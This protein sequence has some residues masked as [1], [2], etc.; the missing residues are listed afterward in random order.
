M[1]LIELLGRP[2]HG[3]GNFDDLPKKA[4]GL[5][6]Y[7][8]MYSGRA[9]PREKLVDLLWTNSAAE[10]GRHSLRQSLAAIR[11]ALGPDARDHIKTTGDDVLF[12]TSDVIEVDAR[13]F[14]VLAQSAVLADL[15]AA[16]ELYRGEFLADFDVESEAFMDWVGLERNRLELM[17][18]G[19][20]YRLATTLSNSCDHDNAII[21]AQ[22]LVGVDA[23]R[24]D[25]H[26]LL[27]Q[28]YANVGRRGEAIR[29]FVSCSDHLRRELGV[30]PDERTVALADAIRA[31]TS[32]LD[33]VQDTSANL[34]PDGGVLTLAAD[35]EPAGPLPSSADGAEC[36]AATGAVINRSREEGQPS[37]Y[38]G[39]R[40]PL[41]IMA[42]ELTWLTAYPDVEDFLPTNEACYRRCA[43]IIER[44]HGYIARCAGDGLIAYFGYPHARE[45]D[46]E[47]SVRAA[48]ALRQLAAQLS[49]E[50]GTAVQLCT[51]IATGI[52]VIGDEQRT[53]EQTVLGDTLILSLSSRL[54]AMAKPGQ[55]II[56]RS[57]QRLLGR[58][59][60]YHEQGG[61]DLKGLPTPVETAQVLGESGI[62]S[63]F[64]AHHPAKLTPVV[65]R[66]EEIGLL[67]RRW[68]RAKNGEGSIVL[69]VGE[70]G[71]GKSRIAQAALDLLSGER[72]ARWRLFCSPH[73]QDSPLFPFTNQL[74]RAS[75]FRR[76]DTNEERLLKL[77]MM[78]GQS[79]T[80]RGNAMAL[81][82][83]LLSIPTG[84]RY[85]LPA[86]TPQQRKEKTLEALAA[87]VEGLAASQP[88]LLVF[89]DVHWAD[90]TSLELLDLI[91]ERTPQRRLLLILTARP[92]FASPWADRI[93]TT[94]VALGR[95]PPRQS[96]AIIAGVVQGKYLPKDISNK[97]LDRADGIPLFIEELTKAVVESDA[98][99]GDGDHGTAKGPRPTPEIPM[100]LH[101]SLLARID[102]TGP[103]RE[104]VQIG[105]AL[106]RRFS[107][108]LISA[109]AAMPQHR[110]EEALAGLVEAEL[111]WRRGN[112]P[113]AEYTFKHALVQE[114]AYG[115]LRRE[116][117]RSLHARIAE[118][119][120]SQF[121]NIADAR[122]ELLAHHYTEAGLLEK[123]AALW[124]KAGQLSLARSALKEASA[125]LTRALDLIEALP[126]TPSLRQ[127]QIKLQIAFANS[128][129]H[130][131]GY[132]A[133]ETKK[134]LAYARLLVERAEVLGEPT[135]DPLLLLSVL[136]GFWVANHVAFNGDAV[137]DLAVEFITLAQ[138]QKTVF[139]LVV[140]HRVMGTS[141]LYLGEI[142]ESLTHLDR[143]L[144]L[145]EP[146]EQRALA[147]RFGQ[148]AGV[149]I[150]SNRP[151]ALWL[152]GYPEAALTDA[153]EAL[154]QARRFGQTATLL[155]AL[156]RIAWFHLVIGNY[157]TAAAQ[158]RELLAV[159]ENMEGSYW[160]AAA[161]MLQGCLFALTGNGA[162]AIDMIT[163][164]I[165]ASRLTG[166]NL[167][168]MPWY[169]SC[170]A[171]AHIALGQFDEAKRYI[172]EALSAMGTTKESWQ[173]SDI[174][175]IAGDLE[176][177][178]IEPNMGNAQTYYEHAVT[179]AREQKAKSWEL[180][181][182]TGL[183][184]LWRQQGRREDALALLAPI[185]GWFT[186]GFYTAD[187]RTARALLDE[188]TMG[189]S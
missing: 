97:I 159:T 13:R 67:L 115:T 142:A 14:E 169:L 156:T 126:G 96:E 120:E 104:I 59:F 170:L 93:Q 58:I 148:D 55:I 172:C 69:L 2:R 79:M 101:A 161:T 63:R 111:I 36:L 100:T 105:A 138:T 171:T 70:P 151:L 86:L 99:A 149:A 117:R 145:Y 71:I 177:M 184:L 65:G 81:F 26:R 76:V 110:L 157:D 77:E 107:H 64:E 139:P 41:T 22:R 60:D 49:T 16:N 72:H 116:P 112:P 188:L 35:V 121:A 155:Y 98:L 123:A 140:G 47:N 12:A 89:E 29:Q 133:P 166:W 57:T 21:A 7:L 125:Q 187:L 153:D 20:L 165:A 19:M 128:L 150:L 27:M 103:G 162:S 40:R 33:L 62:E 17:A 52:A 130:T 158:T 39:Q 132:A 163:S 122:P 1:P 168:R 136:H 102:R 73:H 91:I 129:M 74:E 78:L 3:G 173:E 124:G 84:D 25:G 9:I 88:L 11:R 143:A 53:K 94:S 141:Q 10:Q 113:D 181:A 6:A 182:A 189:A 146:A 46:A 42:S 37:L 68:R 167:L 178:S 160:T 119:L 50:L 176:L 131:K 135:E 51:G 183:A 92:E 43:D 56:D 66:E 31:G 45:Q 164:G 87:H 108:H 174:V 4:K 147:T 154:N 75:G 32:A 80:D 137:R 179:L 82:A 114:A 127:E 48:L 18:C 152:L 15:I 95:L 34:A 175:R 54:Q 24:E 8:A 83:Q 90:P 109:V 180:R 28:L 85:P 144:L 186:E 38:P 44:H 30:A 106:G 118:T 5:L 23:L 134:A 185:Y 61:V